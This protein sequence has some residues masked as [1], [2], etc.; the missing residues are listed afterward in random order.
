[1]RMKCPKSQSDE[2][3]PVEIKGVKIDACAQ[4]KGLWFD[5]DELRKIKDIT[6][7]DAN[8]LDVDLWTDESKL[9]AKESPKKCPACANALYAIEYGDS[10]TEIDFCKNC[11]G[12]WLDK[13]DLSKIIAFVKTKSADELLGNYWFNLVNEAKEVFTGPEDFKSE[14]GDVLTLLDL[15]KYKL[16]TQHEKL[17]RI[18]IS[19]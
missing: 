5:K 10:G 12:V 3:T 4:C 17:S 9:S 18:V 2:L 19:L 11:Q 6:A 16:M 8:W 14:L 15:F 1:M 7:S 13:N